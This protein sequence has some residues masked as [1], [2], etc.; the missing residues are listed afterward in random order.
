[1]RRGNKVYYIYLGLQGTKEIFG[2][3]KV[4]EGMHP[5]VVGSSLRNGHFT[6]GGICFYDTK[7]KL[8]KW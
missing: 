6:Y 2:K 1:M 4:N 3:A 5:G 7:V 8:I